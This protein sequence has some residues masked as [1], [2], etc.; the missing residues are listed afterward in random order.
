[1]QLKLTGLLLTKKDKAVIQKDLAWE[2][3][4]NRNMGLDCDVEMW[5]QFYH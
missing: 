1:M 4:N 3:D 5:K 2:F